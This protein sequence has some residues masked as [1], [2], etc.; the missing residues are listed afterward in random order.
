METNNAAQRRQ[1]RSFRLGWHLA[2]AANA[3][4]CS[5]RQAGD[6]LERRG[7]QFK[8]WTHRDTT[9]FCNGA[10]DGALGDRFR[11]NLTR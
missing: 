3:G 7:R 8:G 2:N 1:R 10:E 4:L 5:P 9:A 11:L 6:E